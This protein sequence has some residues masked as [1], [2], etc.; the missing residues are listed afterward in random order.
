MPKISFL[1]SAYNSERFMDRRLRNLLVEQTE[2]DIE[3]IVVDSCSEQNEKAI[4]DK[5][6][7]MYPEKVVY[8]KQDKR[9]PYG[10]SWLD[11][12]KIAKSSWVC[13][14]NTD[15]LFHK[16]FASIMSNSASKLLNDQCKMSF[17]Y[18]GIHVVNEQGKTVAAGER[19]PQ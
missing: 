10:V 15:D 9:T 19:P 7:A 2:K 6:Q 13:N 11:G 12:M 14:S 1:V 17:A 16:N 18:T 3:V 4:V 5:W 8:L